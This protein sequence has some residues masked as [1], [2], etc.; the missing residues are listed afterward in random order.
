MRENS[1]LLGESGNPE[2]ETHPE[3]G[4]EASELSYAIHDVVLT[5]YVEP[6]EPGFRQV[7]FDHR[8]VGVD[9]KK[10]PDRKSGP[11]RKKKPAPKLV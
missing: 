11:N 10:G 7:A 5:Y 1:E 9:R 6:F 8:R 3:I 4:L 2:A